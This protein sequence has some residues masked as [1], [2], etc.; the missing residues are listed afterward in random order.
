[1]GTA[2]VQNGNGNASVPGKTLNLTFTGAPTAANL[3]VAT[4]GFSA[5]PG[6]ITPPAGWTQIG[7]TQ[8]RATTVAIWKADFYSKNCA[9]TNPVAFN[10]TNNA[11]AACEASEY[12]G[13]DTSTPLESSQI[14]GGADSTPTTA[15]IT[16][17]NDNDRMV[18]LFAQ[19]TSGVTNPVFSV[20]TNS[21][22]DLA[23]SDTG[24]PKITA[25]VSDAVETSAGP[26][27]GTAVTSD[28]NCDWLTRIVA[29][30]P[31][32]PPVVT[33]PPARV[34]FLPVHPAQIYE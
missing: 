15:N 10:W 13:A 1:M 12:S 17:T 18:A 11:L 27:S 16:T 3:L 9:T 8:T 32:A 23:Q 6:A 26:H 2:F 5:N 19:S 21:Y 4:I 31:A 33:P 34:F 7:T 14:N 29:F 25:A 30:I 20:P 28:T 24:I 22:T